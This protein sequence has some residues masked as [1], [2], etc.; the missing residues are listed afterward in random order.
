MKYLESRARKI[1][2]VLGVILIFSLIFNTTHSAYIAYGDNFSASMQS[3]NQLESLKIQLLGTIGRPTSIIYYLNQVKSFLSS[4]YVEGTESTQATTGITVSITGTNVA[5]T[6]S[7]DYYIEAMANDASGNPYRFLEGNS[8]SVT[9]GGAN[10]DLTNQTT[11]INHLEAMGLSTT[12]SHTID[13]YVYVQA[14]ATGAVSGDTLTSE[15]TKTKFDT[16]FYGYGTVE[17]ATMGHWVDDGWMYGGGQM[18]LS[19][20]LNNDTYSPIADGTLNWIEFAASHKHSGAD[21]FCGVIYEFEGSQGAT[22]FVAKSSNPSP[23]YS[24]ITEYHADFPGNEPIYADTEYVL[25]VW[26][27]EDDDD[28]DW[29]IRMD[30]G[31]SGTRWRDEWEYRSGQEPHDPFEG[32]S[33]I[34]NLGALKVQVNYN[35]IG[36]AASWY[37]I[38]AS[39]LDMPLG[40]T[41][42][43]LVMI[44]LS[45]YLVT[46][47]LK[48]NK[49]ETTKQS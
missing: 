12:A 14:Q 30:H 29:K 5:S 31:T 24:T 21:W 3:Q 44:A 13:Y 19:T 4:Y 37:Q 2:L 7:V 18:W 15:I 9:V 38:P 8:T 32:D 17:S 6:A 42:G 10:L 43:S 36:Y 28:T 23:V 45:G 34:M 40:Q 48:E 47:V 1:G 27:E 20:D 49:N 25:G 35:Y 39:I 11:I 26:T 41:L 16:V 22:D 33:R 46:S